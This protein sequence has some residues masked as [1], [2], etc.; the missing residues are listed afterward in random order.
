MFTDSDF[1]MA[2]GL[3][4]IGSIATTTLILVNKYLK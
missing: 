2:L 4:I 1:K 3:S